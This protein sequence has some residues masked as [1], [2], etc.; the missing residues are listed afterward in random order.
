MKAILSLLLLLLLLISAVEGSKF[1]E[2]YGDLLQE[3][4]KHN[5]KN[6]NNINDNNNNNNKY[7]PS[8]KGTQSKFKTMYSDYMGFKDKDS[9]VCT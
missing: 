1:K 4:Q 2:L 9:T 5:N 7:D 3:K 8:K 6:N